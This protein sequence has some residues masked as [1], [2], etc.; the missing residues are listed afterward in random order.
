LAP[1]RAIDVRY[2]LVYGSLRRVAS[3][4]FRPAFQRR[5]ESV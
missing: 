2:A 5:E 3:D 1:F 4:E